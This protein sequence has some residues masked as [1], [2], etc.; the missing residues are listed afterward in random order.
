M[1]AL[2]RLDLPADFEWQTLLE[3]HQRDPQ[4]VAE[5]SNAQSLEKAWCGQGQAICLRLEREQATAA[6][7]ASVQVFLSTAAS[8]PAHAEELGSTLL[9]RLRHMLG[10]EQ[11]VADF[12][13]AWHLHPQLGPLLEARPGLR[14]PQTATVFEALSWAITGQQISVGAAVALRRR[15]IQACGIRHPG[16]LYCYPDAQAVALLG[17][18]GLRQLG[19]SATK[20][21][22][23]EEIS[24]LLLSGQLDLETVSDPETL[25]SALLAIRGIGPWTVHYTLLRGLAHLDASLEGDAGVRRGLQRLLQQPDKVSPAQA[26]DWLAPFSP[27]RALVAAHLWRL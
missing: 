14:L 10:L 20:A 24:Q 27:W 26:R 23:L 25:G 15:L 6:G 13:A 22:C 21:G 16:G 1:T 5:R 18:N 4:A 12:Y 8:H 7:P 11:A 17:A 3:F 2:T 9:P 19:F